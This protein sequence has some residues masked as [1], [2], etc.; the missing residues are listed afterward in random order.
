MCHSNFTFWFRK[1][2]PQG[3]YEQSVGCGKGTVMWNRRPNVSGERP[4]LAR[5]NQL[6]KHFSQAGEG[7]HISLCYQ[8]HYSAFRGKKGRHHEQDGL[9]A[10]TKYER[11]VEMWHLSLSLS[12]TSWARSGI[13]YSPNANTNCLADLRDN[14]SVD[15]YQWH[16]C[17]RET[18]G[19]YHCPLSHTSSVHT[20]EMGNGLGDSEPPSLLTSFPTNSN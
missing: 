5:C 6:I 13:W 8:I 18:D 3:G 11:E 2:P 4:I 14:G 10:H 16:N 20:Q 9:E 1:R 17:A 15:V 7:C 19:N 12:V